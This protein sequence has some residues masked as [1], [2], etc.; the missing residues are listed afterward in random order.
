M[1]ARGNVFSFERA[2][3]W[4]VSDA[5]IAHGQLDPAALPAAPATS[6]A[7]EIYGP[8]SAT[9][10]DAVF[11]RA[12]FRG[13]GKYEGAGD[14]G[15]ETL[16][17]GQLV[18][19]QLQPDVDALFTDS[20]V[21][22]ASLTNVQ[23][24]SPDSLNPSPVQVGL[25]LVTKIQR[26]DSAAAGQNKFLNIIYPLVQMRKRTPNPTQ[27]GGVNPGAVTLTFNPAV[28]T[29]FPTGVALS[30]AQGWTDNSE[31]HYRLISDYGQALTFFLADGVATTYTLA[32]KPVHSDVTGGKTYNW[33]AKD[34]VLTAPTSVSTTTAVVTLAAAGS[35]G[36]LHVALYQTQYLT[37]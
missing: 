28:S 4:R 30:S 1:S 24:S 22:T 14:M 31:F 32:F 5:G 12:E 17:E 35:S 33:Y 18:V 15:L 19:S 34:G 20:T 9:L 37:P 13:G 26:R 10:P 11:A 2:F 8:I 21:D 27:E 16:N 36:D 29:Y 7:L 3:V 23:I 25:L 6:H